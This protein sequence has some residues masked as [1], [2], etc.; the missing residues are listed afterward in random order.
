MSRERHNVAFTVLLISIIAGGCGTRVQSPGEKKQATAVASQPPGITVGN[1]SNNV[2]LDGKADGWE[3]VPPVWEE[4][5]AA[6][7]GPFE[8]GI[9]IKQVYLVNDAHHLYVFFRT[10][11]SLR[12]RYE[13][14]PESGE[15]CDLYFDTDNDAGTGCKDVD[16]FD[17]GK[18]NGYEL[19]AWIPVGIYTGTDGA[20]PFVTYDLLG[21]D[22][23]GNFAL[24]ASVESQS[25]R[26]PDAL[27][28]H[29]DDGVEMAIPL[30]RLGVD[31]GATIRVLLKEA[32]DPFAKERYSEGVYTLR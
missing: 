3:G 13:K 11:P 30:E 17:F 31:V 26:E 22:E 14:S 27:I 6:G 18:I 1:S 29:G 32:A 2:T 20:E 25:S 8:S 16:G 5:G 15:L 12:A 23:N 28:A 10:T 19:K 9:D 7:Q 4:A 21:A 24:S